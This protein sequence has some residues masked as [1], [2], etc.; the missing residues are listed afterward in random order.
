[1][2]KAASTTRAAQVTIVAEAT[3]WL[4][5]QTEEYFARR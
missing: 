4:Q 3:L 2:H 1:V 5:E